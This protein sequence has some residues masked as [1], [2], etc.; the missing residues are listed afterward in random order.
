M[1]LVSA[2]ISEM[3]FTDR[4]PSKTIMANSMLRTQLGADLVPETEAQAQARYAEQ[5][6]S[7]GLTIPSPQD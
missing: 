1:F 3:F 6:A 5:L 2:D 4:P 7:E